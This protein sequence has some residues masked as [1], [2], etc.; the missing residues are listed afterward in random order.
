MLVSVHGHLP[1]VRKWSNFDIV[2]FINDLAT[3]ELANDVN[4]LFD[5][6]NSTMTTLVDKHAP[7]RTVSRRQQQHAPWY[8]AEC[9]SMKRE[10]RHLESV[11]C[12]HRFPR[13]HLEWWTADSTLSSATVKRE[14][15]L[16]RFKTFKTL[17]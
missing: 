4:Y 12:R 2:D 17:P 15:V 3:S 16:K 1:S 8:D 11:F 13:C 7:Q 6:Y 14:N 5:L 10:V 9:Y